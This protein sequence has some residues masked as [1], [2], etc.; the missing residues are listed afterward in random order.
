MSESQK[1]KRQ[2]A[3]RPRVDVTPYRHLQYGGASSSM[4]VG[5]RYYSTEAGN[6]RVARAG[7]TANNPL[8]FRA[9]PS[10]NPET[11]D[12]TEP[13]RL[14]TTAGDYSQWLRTMPGLKRI[15]LDDTPLSCLLYDPRW[16]ASDNYLPSDNPWSV[17]YYAIKQATE[18][19]EALIGRRNVATSKWAPVFKDKMNSKPDNKVTFIRAAVF[20][21]AK[22]NEPYVAGRKPPSGFGARDSA[23]IVEIQS[24]G[25]YMALNE[26]LNEINDPNADS[27][28]IAGRYKYADFTDLATGPFIYFYNP[29]KQANAVATATGELVVQA[30]AGVELEEPEEELPGDAGGQQ[31]QSRGYAIKVSDKFLYRKAGTTKTYRA[32]ANLTEYTDLFFER[33]VWWDD[34]LHVPP[35]EQLCLWIAQAFRGMPNLLRFGWQRNDEFFTDEVNGVLA[36]RTQGQG[37]EVPG[38]DEE[39]RGEDD[40]FEEE[41]EE[42]P[43]AASRSTLTAKS[44][45]AAVEEEEE[46]EEGFG[47]EAEDEL[48]GESSEEENAENEE[49]TV[50]TS[51]ELSEDETSNEDEEEEQ[52]E[53]PPKLAAKPTLKLGDPGKPALG[54]KPKS[55]AGVPFDTEDDE[56]A[57]KKAAAKKPATKPVK[58]VSKKAAGKKA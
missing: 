10:I 43:R 26:A 54:L 56:M 49:E 39:D 48:L 18:S 52:A 12:S 13:A 25:G 30:A 17:L 46:V 53:Q 23:N 32:N 38:D 7:W 29:E 2:L 5:N 31:Q 40:G 41:V 8:V 9:L 27:D 22:M 4:P 47:V 51:E 36:A 21:G 19:G 57:K 58:K 6:I 3:R 55:D 28:D 24:T 1:P 15:G 20:Q 33:Y 34:I 44:K 11:L 42:T 14:S 37:V 35:T 16:I 50:D 45:P